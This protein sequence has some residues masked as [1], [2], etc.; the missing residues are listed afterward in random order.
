MSR[1]LPTQKSRSYEQRPEAAKYL[2]KFTDIM[3]DIDNPKDALAAYNDKE[4]ATFYDNS[5][6]RSVAGKAGVRRAG[7]WTAWEH[8]LDATGTTTTLP[9][10]QEAGELL[11]KNNPAWADDQEYAIIAAFR[12]G[13]IVYE[14]ALAEKMKFVVTKLRAD[15]PAEMSDN[16]KACWRE[17][18][19]AAT[20]EYIA[21]WP[22]S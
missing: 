10:P 5:A 19:D 14:D 6:N 4:A 13:V 20:A 2:I 12:D 15:A 3:L 21:A 17:G 22:A 9:T 1:P 8:Q 11:H 7:R 16:E 18:I